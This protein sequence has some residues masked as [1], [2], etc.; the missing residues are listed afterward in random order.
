ML[1]LWSIQN[2]NICVVH[3]LKKCPEHF[4]NTVIANIYRWPQECSLKNEEKK[5]TLELLN[6]FKTTEQEKQHWT[7]I[8]ILYNVYTVPWL[9]SKSK[10]LDSPPLFLVNNCMVNL[11]DFFPWILP[12]SGLF[13]FLFKRG[14]VWHFYTDIFFDAIFKWIFFYIHFLIF[15]C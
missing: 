2:T 4:R 7:S 12:G 11:D 8:L 14:Q 1:H 10:S 6:F 3:Y 15:H 13:D 9:K 5:I